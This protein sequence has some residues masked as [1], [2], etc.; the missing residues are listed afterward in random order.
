MGGW[1]RHSIDCLSSSVRRRGPCFGISWRVHGPL[2]CR[3]VLHATGADDP[4]QGPR[5]A[6][7]NR[8]NS[9]RRIRLLVCTGETLES[10][11]PLG[12]SRHTRN[13]RVFRAI[14]QRTCGSCWTSSESV[15]LDRSVSLNLQSHFDNIADA[16]YRIVDRIWYDIGYY[17]RREG[18]FLREHVRRP[19]NLAIDA[20]C[21]PGRHLPTLKEHS[22]RVIAIDFSRQML[23]NARKG[24]PSN[25]QVG[26]DL[27]QADV[28][29]LPLKANAADLVINF[30]VLEHLPGGLAD[31]RTTLEE[32]GRVLKPRGSLV[33]EVPL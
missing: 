27:V 11:C 17:H 15:H 10:C 12:G 3:T 19:V 23:N 32:F 25:R 2:R 16:Y 24:M 5:P 6:G 28:R 30:E 9:P 1:V 29:H 18:E 31:A 4:T 22:H 26:V 14:A 7:W 21:G 8:C 20:G 13:R 33:V